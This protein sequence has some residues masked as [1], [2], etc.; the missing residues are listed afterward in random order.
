MI[1]ILYFSKNYNSSS[2]GCRDCCCHHSFPL[3]ET[4]AVLLQCILQATTCPGLREMGNELVLFS[5]KSDRPFHFCLWNPSS[6]FNAQDILFYTTL[7]Q[8]H[9]RNIKF[10]IKSRISIHFAY[11]ASIALFT[12]NSLLHQSSFF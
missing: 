3:G 1:Q 9:M 7:P 5:F 2:R 6:Y 10:I 4:N 11:S 12:I 8:I